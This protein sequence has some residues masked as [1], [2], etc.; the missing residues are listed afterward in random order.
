M[1]RSQLIEQLKSLVSTGTSLYPCQEEY[2]RVIQRARPPVTEEDIAYA[3][4]LLGYP[5]PPFLKRIYL[6]VGNG[7]FG[8]GYGLASLLTPEG[9]SAHVYR[10]IVHTTLHYR[11]RSWPETLL[12]LCDWGCAIY[13]S[14]DCS[15]L[16][17]PIVRSEQTQH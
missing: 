7:G 17:Y 4:A 6:E 3:E 12:F 16:V 15:T 5:L 1:D 8:P 11:G 13:S 14:V 9:E 10:S 2:R